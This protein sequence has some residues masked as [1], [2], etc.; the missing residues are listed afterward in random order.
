MKRKRE[1]QSGVKRKRDE[2]IHG[3]REREVRQ[4]ERTEMLK[5][6]EKGWTEIKRRE[7]DVREGAVK[8]DR[9]KMRRV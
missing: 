3:E 2:N 5:N 9:F 6:M 8:R 7:R 1:W 4:I